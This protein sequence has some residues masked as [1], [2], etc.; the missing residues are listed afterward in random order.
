MSRKEVC[1]ECYLEKEHCRPF[2]TLPTGEEEFVCPACWQELELD[3]F[4][5]DFTTSAKTDMEC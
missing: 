2:N 5:Y 3:K 4:L 1:T